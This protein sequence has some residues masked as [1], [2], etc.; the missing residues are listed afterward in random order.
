MIVAICILLLVGFGI[1]FLKI[2]DR[3]LLQT[4][5]QTN[6]GTKSERKLV[7]KLLKLGFQPEAIFHDLYLRK[8][9]GHYSQ[10]DLVLATKVGLLVF[11]VKDYRGWIFGTGY[12][13]KWTQVLAFGKEKYR[14]YNPILQNKKHIIDLRKQVRQFENLPFFS[15]VVFY[16]NCKFKDISFVP[17]G[18]YLIKA[19]RIKRVLKT[20]LNENE[21]ANYTNKN[22]EVRILKNAVKNGENKE[23]QKKHLENIE[24][25][26]GVK[27]IFE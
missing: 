20:I 14:F 7:L 19:N 6:R 24:N 10:I 23:V 15:I 27:R 4:V 9:N 21:P 18:T 25:M 1:I 22:E 3:K 11:E 12:M 8:P 2:R 5:T 16:G 13:Q 17:E 26:L